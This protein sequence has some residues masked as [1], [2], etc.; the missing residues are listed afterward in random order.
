MDGTNKLLQL[1]LCDINGKYI[2]HVGHSIVNSSAPWSYNSKSLFVPLN[3]LGKTHIC[4]VPDN[5]QYIDYIGSGNENIVI[6]YQASLIFMIIKNNLR[7][8]N[9]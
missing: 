2:K 7:H 5:C 9:F 3:K 4:W 6:V 8:A 1:K